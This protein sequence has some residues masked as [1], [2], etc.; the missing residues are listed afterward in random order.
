MLSRQDFFDRVD[1]LA[2]EKDNNEK[3]NLA[4]LMLFIPHGILFGQNFSQDE[5][6]LLLEKGWKDFSDNFFFSYF[7]TRLGWP[8]YLIIADVEQQ[9]LIKAL[10]EIFNSNEFKNYWR[11]AF[12]FL[13]RGNP[14]IL[15]S[16]IYL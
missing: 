14:N 16:I 11:A 1:L 9:D 7:C 13:K 10:E 8:R 4:I 6:K 12:S 2:N 3:G 15:H 5:E